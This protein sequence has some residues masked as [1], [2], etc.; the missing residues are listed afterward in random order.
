M[1]SSAHHHGC[2][3]LPCPH[4]SSTRLDQPEEEAEGTSKYT[5]F[6]FSLVTFRVEDRLFRVPRHA[7]E[8]ES[9]VFRS[10]FSLPQGSLLVDGMSN[11][12]PIHLPGVTVKDFACLI[13]VLY[14]SVSTFL[15]KGNLSIS[16]EDWI[17]V[18]HLSRMWA[19]D[20][21]RDLSVSML[22]ELDPV[23]KLQL[24]C[25]CGVDQWRRPALTKL[26]QRMEPLSREEG[27]MLGME[28]VI[29]VTI[30][31][32][33]CLRKMLQNS[34]TYGSEEIWRRAAESAIDEVF[35]KGSNPSDESISRS[36]IHKVCSKN[37]PLSF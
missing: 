8:E 16:T 3:A 21:L 30:A 24:A 27:D 35:I 22:E 32:D 2:N 1:D 18:L 20:R 10:M 7:F 11:E 29:K 6:Y 34:Y 9:E 36:G 14:P 31:R 15:P 4:T 17:S 5:D 37:R 19:F 26:V 13:N 28:T 33:K 23:K 25:S 12:N